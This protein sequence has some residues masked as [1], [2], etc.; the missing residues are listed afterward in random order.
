MLSRCVI[1]TLLLFSSAAASADAYTVDVSAEPVKAG[2]W[3]VEYVLS[4]P[5]PALVFARGNGDYRVESW[6]LPRGFEIDRLG[7]TDRIRRKN[8]KPFS[9]LVATVDTYSERIPKDYTPFIKFSDGSVALFTG[10]FIVG[11]PELDSDGE[12][13][14]GASNENMRWPQSA[15]ITLDPGRFGTM[16]AG[17]AERGWVDGEK[18]MLE[19]LISFKRAGCDG[20]LTYFAPDAAKALQG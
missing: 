17:A 10:Q 8:G 13:V 5:V 11:V 19:S 15:S 18:I 2:Q 6:R 20:I 9:R 7:A 1:P 14:D 4:K 3:E 12:F 16:I